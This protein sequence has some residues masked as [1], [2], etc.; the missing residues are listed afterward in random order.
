MYGFKN[1]RCGSDESLSDY[2]KKHRATAITMKIVNER[3]IIIIT[4]TTI[5]IIITT[6]SHQSSVIMFM[7]SIGH[8]GIKRKIYG[9]VRE[10]TGIP[11]S[12]YSPF[13]E[14]PHMNS[15]QNHLFIFMQYT[16]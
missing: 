4:T 12:G 9:G 3:I 11:A 8:Q 15:G 13:V 10:V 7:P 6:I 1:E 2:K 14:T 16:N 5:I